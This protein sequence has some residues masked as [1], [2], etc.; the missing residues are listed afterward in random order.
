M[1]K[2]KVCGLTSVADA[3]SVVAAGA[4]AVGLNFYEPSPRYIGVQLAGEI[5]AAVR[6]QAVRVGLFV[7]AN[8]NTILQTVASVDLDAIQ[9]HGDEPAGFCS[10]VKDKTSLPIIRAF[11]CK[12]DSLENVALYICASA[13]SIDAALIDAYDP[14]LYGGAGK[15][16]DWPMLA[17]H[18]GS[19]EGI[20]L[21][22]AGGLNPQNVA[23]AIEAAQPAGVDIASGVESS[24]GVKD[25]QLVA[26]LVAAANRHF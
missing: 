5:S 3:T 6:G 7:N 26:A 12:D 25:A 13:G 23:R 1:F 11:R 8:I 16:V 22:L 20:P 4:D 24:P 9:L 14:D 19:L 17:P 2:I 10:E 15:C 21:I 18:Q